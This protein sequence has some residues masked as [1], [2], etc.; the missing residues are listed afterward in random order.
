MTALCVF[1][2]FNPA[3]CEIVGTRGEITIRLLS[4]VNHLNGTAAHERESKERARDIERL[5]EER[6]RA[7][8]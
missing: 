1:F 3:V 6:E 5:C 2:L 8:E 7:E 4:S